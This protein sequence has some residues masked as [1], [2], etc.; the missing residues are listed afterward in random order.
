LF[1]YLLVVAENERL[2]ELIFKIKEEMEAKLRLLERSLED[3]RSREKDLQSEIG[4]KDKLNELIK[5][6]E[7]KIALLSM[8]V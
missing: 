5:Q 8:E 4:E 2:N 1:R 3:M 6:Y 7:N